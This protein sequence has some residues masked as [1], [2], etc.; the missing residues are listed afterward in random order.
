MIST[1][2]MNGG[3]VTPNCPAC[4]SDTKAFAPNLYRCQ[5]RDCWREVMREPGGMIVI[6]TMTPERIRAHNE[7]FP[8]QM[9]QIDRMESKLDRI[10]GGEIRPGTG[11]SGPAP[12][13][14]Q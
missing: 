2:K 9:S 11:G 12:W 13:I 14:Y 8:P 6:N 5:N 4:E 7:M 1:D 10:L 3:E